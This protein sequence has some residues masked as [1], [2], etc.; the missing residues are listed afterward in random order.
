MKKED[1]RPIE[2]GRSSFDASRKP[3]KGLFHKLITKKEDNG[4][5]FVR[6]LIETE[7]GKLEEVPYDT[8]RF[9]D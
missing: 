4:E 9:T 1:Y 6:A 5:E 7:D 2:Y 3:K 8:I